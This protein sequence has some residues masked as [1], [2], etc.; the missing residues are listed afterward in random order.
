VT[1]EIH[2]LWSEAYAQGRQANQ[3]RRARV[4]RHPDLAARLCAPPLG[5]QRAEQ[6]NGFVPP[7][8]LPADLNGVTRINTSP[9]RA[10]LV[11]I[12]AEAMRRP[13]K[14]VSREGEQGE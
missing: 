1:P 6:W 13:V 4:L 3:D 2:D 10:A 5:Y 9:R 12:S 11:E 8:Y 14:P 7:K